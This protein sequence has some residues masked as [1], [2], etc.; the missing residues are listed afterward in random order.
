MDSCIFITLLIA[1]FIL[2][3]NEWV[4]RVKEKFRKKT[5]KVFDHL[6]LNG[7]YLDREFMDRCYDFTENYFKMIAKF[8]IWKKEKFVKDEEAYN[9]IIYKYENEVRGEHEPR[10]K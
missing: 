2:I 9:F 10:G 3:R 8:W 5:R 1:F 6:I 7:K 4:Y